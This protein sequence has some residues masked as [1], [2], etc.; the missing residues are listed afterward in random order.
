M[1]LR[2]NQEQT[3]DSALDQSKGTKTIYIYS[4]RIIEF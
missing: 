1:E 4:I 2:T 3:G